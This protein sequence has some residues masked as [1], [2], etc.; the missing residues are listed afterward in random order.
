MSVLPSTVATSPTWLLSTWYVVLTA[1][2]LTFTF[3]FILINLHL[4]LNSRMEL[5]ATILDR[6][7]L[8]TTSDGKKKL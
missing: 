1:E 2:E 8:E 7:A 3:Y 6:A 5:A 4:P